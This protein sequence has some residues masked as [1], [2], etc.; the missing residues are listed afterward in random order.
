MKDVIEVLFIDQGIQLLMTD[1]MGDPTYHI[2]NFK[3]LSSDNRSHLKDLFAVFDIGFAS[4]ADSLYL[5]NYRNKLPY[6]GHLVMTIHGEGRN[7][8]LV[9]LDRDEE[10]AQIQHD[11][12]AIFGFKLDPLWQWHVPGYFG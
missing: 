11:I 8:S 3:N 7:Q 6:H 5:S 9:I 2:D 1:I 12:L 4:F 10:I